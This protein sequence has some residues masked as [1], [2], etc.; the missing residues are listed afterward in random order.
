MN[1]FLTR[2][3]SP[4][5]TTLG[6]NVDKPRPFLGVDLAS[7]PDKT[8]M[9]VHDSRALDSDLMAKGCTEFAAITVE[10]WMSLPVE[11]E[12]R[13]VDGRIAGFDGC[14]GVSWRPHGKYVVIDQ[15]L[16]AERVLAPGM[17]YRVPG[18]TITNH[19]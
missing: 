9:W 5:P 8:V 4:I 3:D 18:M 10:A 15:M 11:K 16:R 12:H 17:S 6:N 14:W 1:D 7:Q 13:V 19:P 2:F